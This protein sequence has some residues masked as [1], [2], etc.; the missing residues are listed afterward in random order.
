MMAFRRAY[1]FSP[2]LFTGKE[3]ATYALPFLQTTPEEKKRLFCHFL[4]SIDLCLDAFLKRFFSLKSLPFCL[5]F[6]PAKILSLSK[7][8]SSPFVALFRTTY[9]LNACKKQMHIS[10][11][12]CNTVSSRSNS[13]NI[14]F[15]FRCF[16][17]HV[18]PCTVCIVVLDERSSKPKICRK[19]EEIVLIVRLLPPR[20]F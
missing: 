4:H 17:H 7:I 9:R 19:K 3:E 5:R 6:E 1:I 11:M 14:I 16:F 8:N 13:E 15:L 20:G 10:D 18:L 12:V 2:L